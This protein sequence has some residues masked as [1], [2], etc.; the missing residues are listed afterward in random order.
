MLKVEIHETERTMEHEWI[1]LRTRQPEQEMWRGT[2]S[3]PL[4]NRNEGENRICPFS[5]KPSDTVISHGTKKAALGC[6]I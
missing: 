2:V 3:G 5:S 1:K 6:Q 4:R